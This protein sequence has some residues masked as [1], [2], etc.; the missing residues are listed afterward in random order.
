MPKATRKSSAPP[1]E[2]PDP[3]PLATQQ[4]TAPPSLKGA[5]DLWHKRLNHMSGSM[6]L[7]Y[8]KPGIKREV[9]RGW[10]LELRHMADSMEKFLR[11]QS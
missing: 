11:I 8:G 4:P 1:A 6:V 5:L 3:V 2:P 9:L 7:L 10:V